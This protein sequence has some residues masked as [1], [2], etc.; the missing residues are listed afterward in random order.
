MA[1]KMKAAAQAMKAA[2]KLGKNKSECVKVCV[3][4]RPL[5]SKER[6]DGRQIATTA[7]HERGTISVRNPK[8]D[9]SEPPKNFTFDS[10]FGPN[11]VQIDLYNICAAGIVD[12]VMEGFNGTV[13]AYGQTGA[14]SAHPLTILLRL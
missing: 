12:S 9:S 11:T 13:F 5:S 8:A 14:P 6:Q 4:I 7:D 1:S 3:R 2:Q 10:V